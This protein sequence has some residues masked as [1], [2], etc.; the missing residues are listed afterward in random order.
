MTTNSF[1]HFLR[2]QTKK[3]LFVFIIILTGNI[4]FSQSQTQ[5]PARILFLLDASSSMLGDWTKNETRFKAA[6]RLISTIADSI[7]AVN[8]DVAFAVRV[9]GSQYPAQEK[10]CFDS[11]LEVSFS[12]SNNAQIQTRLNYI[13]PRGYSP[14]AWALKETAEKDFTEGNLY[15]YSIILITDGEESCGGDIC[16]TVNT[17]LSSKI[18]FKP[19]IL[20]LMDYAPLKQQYDCMGKYLLVTAEKDINNAVKTII[21]DNRKIL[22]VKAPGLRATAPRPAPASPAPTVT[23]SKPAPPAVT[24]PVKQT[25]APSPAPEKVV[26]PVVT[27]TTPARQKRTLNRVISIKNL[28]KQ[29]LLYTLPDAEPLKVPK[30][31]IKLADMDPEPPKP[32]PAIVQPQPGKTPA[33]PVTTKRTPPKPTTQVTLPY[34]E[35]SED[36]KETSLQIHFTNGQGK[37][38]LT[39]PKLEFLDSK[40]KKVIK[41]AYRN[42]TAGQPDRIPMQPGTYDISIP[43][44]KAKAENVVIEQ[45]K[46]KKITIQISRGALAFYYPTAP[47]RPVKE[48]VALVSKRF[49]PGP[50][51]R[52]RCDEELPYDPANYHIEVNTLPPQMYYIDLDFNSVKLIEILEPGT[53]HITNASNYGKVQFWYQRGDSFVPF[54]EMNVSGNAA[55]QKVEFQPGKYQVRY[56]NPGQPKLKPEIIVFNVKSNQVTSIEL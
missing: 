15:A 26:T 31:V 47:D 27:E 48:Y 55:Q 12:S 53:V 20:S 24:E 34:T 44:S 8:P 46:N 37:V 28:R 11:R 32:R 19:Y 25:P 36:A 17:L 23:R 22:S 51:V 2:T 30:L 16:A 35:I 7:H 13:Q 18:S 21:D 14:I 45:G 38:F 41:T 43:G 1:K 49:E 10:N 33:K 5:R 54:Y 52:Q 3:I 56:S 50:V 9:F 40:T 6:A 29:N 4:S 39:E 42:V